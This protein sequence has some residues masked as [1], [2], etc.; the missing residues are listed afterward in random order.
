[1]QHAPKVRRKD[2]QRSLPAP[3]RLLPCK[4]SGKSV[5]PRV[6]YFSH[7]GFDQEATIAVATRPSRRSPMTL[8]LHQVFVSPI[9]H[10]WWAH[11]HH[12]MDLHLCQ[13][14][15]KV[16]PIRWQQAV[17]PE[18]CEQPSWADATIGRT[19]SWAHYGSYM[20]KTYS[21]SPTSEAESD[22]D[23][24]D[25]FERSLLQFLQRSVDEHVSSSPLPADSPDAVAFWP[26]WK[27]EMLHFCERLLDQLQP[28]L[29]TRRCNHDMEVDSLGVATAVS[30]P[31]SA[32]IINPSQVLP[33]PKLFKNDGLNNS[34]NSWTTT[35]RQI[36]GMPK[37]L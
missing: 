27:S 10:H 11:R 20:Q 29:S 1:M 14:L 8:R 9:H 2:L 31:P 3:V 16:S 19:C 18:L 35:L 24:F 12:Q 26:R 17:L 30:L 5:K 23:G 4:S 21:Y 34:T 33:P 13:P 6:V 25:E 15:H 36:P 22:E 32:H 7:R 28:R 37:P